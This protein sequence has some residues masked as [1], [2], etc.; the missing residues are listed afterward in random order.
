MKK[1][2]FFISLVFSLFFVYD[3]KA[4]VPNFYYDQYGQ[5]NFSGSPQQTDCFRK[6]YFYWNGNECSKIPPIENCI[7]QGGEWYQVQMV[8]RQ[9]F[10]NVCICKNNMFWNGI[11]CVNNLP[12]NKQ[13]KI[14]VWCDKKMQDII[15]NTTPEVMELN[16]CP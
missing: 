10:R 8:K 14:K 9:Y 2:L 6:G 4:F 11:N 15:I 5:L 13:C 3:L 7:S 12:A 1:F 16:T